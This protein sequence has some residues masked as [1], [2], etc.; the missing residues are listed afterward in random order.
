[1]PDSPPHASARRTPSGWKILL[2]ALGV[3]IGLSA[4][5]A[6]GMTGGEPISPC[7]WHGC[8]PSK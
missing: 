3:V 5:Q 1:M 8:A 4:W 6:G 2:A 7:A